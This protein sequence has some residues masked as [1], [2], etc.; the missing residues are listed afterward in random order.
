[1]TK[2][3]FMFNIGI[4]EIALLLAVALIA[5]GPKRMPAAAKSLGRFVRQVKDIF[6]QVTGLWSS[7]SLNPD[8]D[9]VPEDAEVKE[10]P[11][12]KDESSDPL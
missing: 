7:E 6:Q 8:E 5:L 9:S 11:T 2:D 4:P 10:D 12:K 1:M 3:G